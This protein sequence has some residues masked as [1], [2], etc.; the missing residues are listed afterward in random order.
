MKDGGI[1][2]H[3][4]Y[5]A[6]LKSMEGKMWEVILPAQEANKQ[7][8]KQIIVKTHQQGNQVYLRI[9]ADYHLLFLFPRKLWCLYHLSSIDL[10]YG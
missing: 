8:Q 9:L 6:L 1:L 2:A 4:P 7:L 3:E 10:W 5:E